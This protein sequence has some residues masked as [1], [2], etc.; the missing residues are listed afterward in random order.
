VN[1]IGMSSRSTPA[2]AA[3]IGRID[4]RGA[5]PDLELAALAAK[6]ENL[7]ADADAGSA[8]LQFMTAGVVLQASDRSFRAAGESP[9]P[10]GHLGQHKGR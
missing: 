1:V 5:D 6:G 10:A 3:Q 4:R 9:A 8:L 7:L 2:D